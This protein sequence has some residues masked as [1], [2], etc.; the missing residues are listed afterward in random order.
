MIGGDKG[1]KVAL[2]AEKVLTRMVFGSTLG[3][4]SSEI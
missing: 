4:Q 1:E 2:G 3:V